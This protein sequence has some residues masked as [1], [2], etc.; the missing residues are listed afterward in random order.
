M[1]CER[2][3]GRE[4]ETGKEGG[5]EGGEGKRKRERKREREGVTNSRLTP[6]HQTRVDVNHSRGSYNYK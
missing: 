3:R 1:G 6:Y 4:R 5:R 2:G